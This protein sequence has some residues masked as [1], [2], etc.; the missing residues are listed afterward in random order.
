MSKFVTK[1]LP[2]LF[3]ALAMNGCKIVLMA[4]SGGD[5]IGINGHSCLEG[6]LCEFEI[7]TAPFSESFTA[8]PKVGYVFEKWADGHGF[9]CGKST[10]STCTVNLIDNTLG[11]AI[12]SSFTSTY[13]MPIYKNVG[14][15]TDGDGIRNEIDDDDDN[16][17]VLD[18]ND[19]FPFDETESSDSD[20]DGI[21][22]NADNDNDNDGVLDVD[23]AT[24]KVYAY[25]K[26]YNV[27]GDSDSY[28]LIYQNG[29]Y[30]SVNVAIT[31]IEIANLCEYGSSATDFNLY[32]NDTKVVE[33][34]TCLDN[35]GQA[36]P[37][38]FA[39]PEPYFFTISTDAGKF[40]YQYDV[41][42]PETYAII[43]TE[44]KHFSYR[45]SMDASGFYNSETSAAECRFGSS[46][47]VIKNL[48]NERLIVSVCRDVDGLEN[49]ASINEV[50]ADNG[51]ATYYQLLTENWDMV[52]YKG[53]V[54][55]PQSITY[56][57]FDL[58]GGPVE[59]SYTFYDDGSFSNTLRGHCQYDEGDDG[60]MDE[61]LTV[62]GITYRYIVDVC[63]YDPAL[64]VT[65]DE[66]DGSLSGT[67]TRGDFL[68]GLDGQISMNGSV[69]LYADPV[70][71]A[72][73]TSCEAADATSR[74]GFFDVD[75]GA[76]EQW[77]RFK[78]PKSGDTIITTAQ[79]STLP[80]QLS[81]GE[82]TKVSIY[83]A[84]GGTLLASNDNAP[85]AFGAA[86]ISDFSMIENT[87][88]WILL[89]NDFTSSTYEFELFYPEDI[90]H[91]TELNPR[92]LYIGDASVNLAY[93]ADDIEWFSYTLPQSGTVTVTMRDY[94][95]S[96]MYSIEVY[97]V[98]SENVTLTSP[99]DDSAYDGF[100]YTGV[101][102][103]ELLIK[104][105]SRVATNW[106]L[107]LDFIEE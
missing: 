49:I 26:Y 81:R 6:N 33:I 65:I 95:H 29:D 92:V 30:G 43:E 22:D 90:A 53:R 39:R 46:A 2:V 17:G 71:V 66:T 38:V 45:H 82:D 76:G 4:P 77:Y 14:I 34:T 97:N 64:T 24:T 23:E 3:I 1:I 21:G 51:V 61:S 84:C 11:A 36:L 78:A 83:D 35:S 69:S 44:Y 98:E 63:Q 86:I 102:G 88:Y 47:Q 62:D 99:D 101:A 74:V 96:G 12:A 105:G 40:E 85:G 60:S 56:H 70:Q 9:L 32:T 100:I 59:Y 7:E 19:S 18:V 91:G 27:G 13:L 104:V 25:F 48:E 37:Y 54:V 8:T 72:G 16:D 31:P 28:R 52:F 20:Q 10:D 73:V 89:G 55:H 68:M 41:L 50:A 103:D 107:N 57:Q 58:G 80:G 93:A 67:T 87:H 5:I 94:N 15:D 79:A 42:I 75:S 106:R